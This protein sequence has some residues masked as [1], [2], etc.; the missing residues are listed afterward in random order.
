MNSI[1]YSLGD[2]KFVKSRIK[3]V[4]M[5]RKILLFFMQTSF[6]SWL[7]MSVIPYIRLTTYYTSLRGW[8]FHR[9][10]QLLKPGHIILTIDRKK[11]TTFLVPGEFTHASFCV[12]KGLEFEVAEM[13]HNN[14]TKSHFFDICKESDRVV[15]LRCSKFD[16]D[17]TK[18]VIERCLSFQGVSY[19]TGF[20]LGVKSLYCSELVYQSDYERRIEA[21]LSDIAGLGRPYISPDGIFNSKNVELV[22]DSDQEKI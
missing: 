4:G 6:Y 11:L 20:E 22:W 14:F 21:D 17:Y 16:E 18:K 5:F 13:T 3:L 10:Y 19:D 15:I 2:G 1:P 12:A 8:K 9:G 7:V